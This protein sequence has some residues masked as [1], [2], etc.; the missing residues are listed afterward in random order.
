MEITE[1]KVRLRDREGNK[2][3]AYATVTFDDSFVVR[4]LKII[5]GR[6]GLFVAMPSRQVREA[7]PNCHHR[8]AL[9]SKFCNQCGKAL[10]FQSVPRKE[11]ED[12]RLDEHRDVAH[13]ITTEARDYLQKKVL[14]A[15]EVERAELP[16]EVKPE[17]GIEQPVS[18]EPGAEQSSEHVEQQSEDTPEQSPEIELNTDQIEKPE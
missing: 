14:E 11:G 1:V 13:P 6:K 4:D 2:L 16:Q 15:Y 8:N 17:P 12:N 5:D 10:E 9:R 7:C 18:T 3:K